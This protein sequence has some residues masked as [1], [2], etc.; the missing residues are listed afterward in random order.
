MPPTDPGKQWLSRLGAL[1][2][3]LLVCLTVQQ[4]VHLVR[5]YRL[6]SML[7]SLVMPTLL[8]AGSFALWRR[9]SPDVA[10]FR[11]GRR[12]ALWA[13]LL[14]GTAVFLVLGGMFLARGNETVTRETL[15]SLA[16]SVALVLLVPVAEEVYFRGLLLNHLKD[17][18]GPWAAACLVSLLFGILHQPSGMSWPMVGFSLFLCLSVLFSETVLWATGFHLLWNALTIIWRRGDAAGVALLLLCAGI[19]VIAIAGLM[20][21]SVLRKESHG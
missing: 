12:A 16:S 2:V 5:D 6:S 20:T 10:L 13:G 15:W 9:W 7:N 8:A 4:S 14:L 3:L 18:L 19:P 21:R 11:G 17:S 1:A